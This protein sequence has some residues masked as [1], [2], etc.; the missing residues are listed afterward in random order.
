MLIDYHKLRD[1]G[2]IKKLKKSQKNLKNK[3]FSKL[4]IL[5][6]MIIRINSTGTG[7]D[8]K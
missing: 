8:G 7:G 5:L 1:T 6:K 2:K 3:A 4:F